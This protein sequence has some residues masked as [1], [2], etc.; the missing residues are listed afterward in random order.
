VVRLSPVFD[1]DVP[2]RVLHGTETAKARELLVS[3]QE[4]PISVIT[5]MEVMAGASPET[6]QSTR[7][8]LGRFAVKNITPE[9]AEEAVRLRKAMQLKLPDAIIYATALISGRMLATFNARDFPE[10]T[11][12]VLLV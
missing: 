11:A 5:W 12:S 3:G 8:F 1:S 9:I 10:G 7:R 4:L 2:L 6:E